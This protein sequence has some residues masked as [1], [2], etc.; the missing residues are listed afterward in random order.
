MAYLDVVIEAEELAAVGLEQVIGHVTGQ[1]TIN[2]A[3]EGEPLMRGFAPHVPREVLKLEQDV[4]P[5]AFDRVNEFVDLVPTHTER[6]LLSS[7]PAIVMQRF[8][9]LG[10]SIDPPSRRTPCRAAAHAVNTRVASLA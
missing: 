10:A 8:A 2:H 3:V 7:R 5:T 1:A 4:G 9:E 6:G